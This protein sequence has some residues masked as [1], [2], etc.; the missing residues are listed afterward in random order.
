MRPGRGTS[1]NAGHHQ[2]RI[3]GNPWAI[4]D[5]T[6]HRSVSAASKQEAVATANELIAAGHNLDL[7][8]GQINNRNLAALGL[9]VEQVF[10]PCTN[11]GAAATI[12][13]WGYQRAKQVHGPGQ[14]A[15][16]A[17]LSAYNTGSLSRGFANGYVQKVLANAGV[18]V[19]L[20][21]PVVAAGSVVRGKIGAVRVG[22]GGRL[23]LFAAPLIP[24]GWQAAPA[25]S[26]AA[27]VPVR[28]APAV[29]YQLPT[30]AQLIPASFTPLP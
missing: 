18:H 27:D 17:A 5:N 14:E 28:T 29:S 25:Q 2:D 10:E 20:A 22:A 8:L 4:G 16:Q 24:A 23:T 26:S 13:T 7:G 21:V 3:R 30:P 9:S 6:T 11:I 12:L 1:D 15:L 19:E